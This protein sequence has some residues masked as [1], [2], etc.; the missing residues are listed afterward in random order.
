MIATLFLRKAGLAFAQESKL[1]M[2]KGKR[3][4]VHT[5][6]LSAIPWRLASATRPGQ[7]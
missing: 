2:R 7:T 1:A 3:A 6:Y 4:R 5:P